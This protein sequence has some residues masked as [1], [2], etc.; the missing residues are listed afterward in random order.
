[1]A[2]QCFFVCIFHVA[3]DPWCPRGG[4]TSVAR[5]SVCPGVS[6]GND[7]HESSPPHLLQYVLALSRYRVDLHL[8]VR[9]PVELRI[10]CHTNRIPVVLANTDRSDRI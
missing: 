2:E 5:R 7:L 8:F 3:R 9:V 4:G 1:M 10:I 6:K